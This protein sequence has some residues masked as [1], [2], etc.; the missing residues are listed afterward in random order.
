MQ[1]N[2]NSSLHVTNDYRKDRI[3]YPEYDVKHHFTFLRILYL[4]L[5][6]I[7]SVNAS[8]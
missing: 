3:S 1:Q 7:L 2:V 6:E 8:L 4:C 5:I